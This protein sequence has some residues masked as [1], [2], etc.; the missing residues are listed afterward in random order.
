MHPLLDLLVDFLTR[1]PSTAFGNSSSTPGIKEGNIEGLMTIPASCALERWMSITRLASILYLEL[2]GIH[3]RGTVF[4]GNVYVLPRN[5]CPKRE[6]DM[7]HTVDPS[8]CYHRCG[9]PW[10][11]RSVV[12]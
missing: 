11:R 6:V 5:Q 10:E 12:G 2:A 7:A 4:H 9:E 1:R 3:G 8:T